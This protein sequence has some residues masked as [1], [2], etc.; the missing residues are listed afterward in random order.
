M[1][2]FLKKE[3]KINPLIGAAGVAAV[4]DSARVAQTMGLKEDSTNHLLI[5]AMAPNIAGVIGS[6]ITAGLLLGFLL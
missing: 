4:P 5:H 3:H 2:I 6:A 1:N